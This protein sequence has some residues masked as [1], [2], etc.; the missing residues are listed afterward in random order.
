[1]LIVFQLLFTYLPVMHTLF[2][3]APLDAATWL[4]IIAVGSSV[5]FLVEL[6]KAAVRRLGG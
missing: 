2:G 3:T 5:L 1:M 6:E 4:S